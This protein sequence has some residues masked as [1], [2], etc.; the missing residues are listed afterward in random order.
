M[1][2]YRAWGRYGALGILGGVA[3]T[4][5]LALSAG[6]AAGHEYRVVALLHQTDLPNIV[7]KIPKWERA[8][9]WLVGQVA[10]SG[11]A[12]GPWARWAAALSSQPVGERVW[13][14]HA[15]VNASF[16]YGSDAQLFGSRDYWEMPDEVVRLNAADCDGFAIFK[17]WLARLAGVPDESLALL[18]GISR[19]TGRTHAV[20]LVADETHDEVLDSLQAAVVDQ[21]AYFGSFTPLALFTLDDIHLFPPAAPH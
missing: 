10:A 6:R 17:F 14:I 9:S 19:V 13:A 2:A 15:R 20:L 3:L 11:P 5:L 16:R 1:V 12:L 8:R 4:S 18:V 7:G 21:T